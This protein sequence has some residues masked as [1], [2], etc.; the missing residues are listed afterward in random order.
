MRGVLILVEVLLLPHGQPIL[1]VGDL[2][3][4]WKTL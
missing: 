1:M 4:K 3:I 2:L